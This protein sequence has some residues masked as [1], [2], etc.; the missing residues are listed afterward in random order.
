M[1]PR[2]FSTEPPPITNPPSEPT[3]VK[4]DAISE[5][6][7]LEGDARRAGEIRDE[8]QGLVRQVLEEALAPLHFRM[9]DLERRIEALERAAAAPPAPVPPPPQLAQRPV[10]PPPAPMAY[11]PPPAAFAP[12]PVQAAAI[13]IARP[14]DLYAA[15]PGPP[16]VPD[17]G[18][19]YDIDV[20]FDGRRRKR[21]VLAL[22]AVLFVVLLG[23]LLTSMAMS[24]SR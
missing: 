2:T 18:P 17:L 23:G 15:I 12:M 11:A 19:S 4:A 24:Y 13:P 5:A 8:A 20:P 10:A 1:A 3:L 9:S 21:K 22:F 14:L 16:R 7:F 6:A